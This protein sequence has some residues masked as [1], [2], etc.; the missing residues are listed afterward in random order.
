M[1]QVEVTPDGTRRLI[2]V[3]GVLDA[4]GG[5]AL[6]A[7]LR[8]AVATH[9]DDVIIDLREATFVSE[10]GLG[11]LLAAR[12]LCERKYIGIALIP[13]P[14]EVQ[15][16]FRMTGTLGVFTWADAQA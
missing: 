5:D 4:D 12:S 11:A 16:K 6:A 14:P 9:P 7:A 2:R 15:R 3:S 8:V 1:V 10:N 13:G